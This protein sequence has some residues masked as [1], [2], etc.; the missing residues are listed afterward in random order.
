MARTRDHVKSDLSRM[1]ALKPEITAR[2]RKYQ[3]VVK[4][5]NQL[6]SQNDTPATPQESFV[7]SA[8]EHK[9]MA[10]QLANRELRRR[11]KDPRD[12]NAVSTL[13]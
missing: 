12:D 8:A 10:L 9:D 11:A 7:L 13:R 4:R 1:E 5:R 2:Y 3:D 6:K